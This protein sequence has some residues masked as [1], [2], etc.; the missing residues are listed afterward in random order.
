MEQRGDYQAAGAAEGRSLR[1]YELTDEQRQLRALL[2]D[3]EFEEFG[4]PVDAIHEALDVLNMAI[5]HKVEAI[6]A[7][8]TEYVVTARAIKTEI[9]R[10]VDRHRRLM[11]RADWLKGY[12]LANLTAAGLRKLE[13]ARFTV[14][15]RANPEALEVVDQGLIP[16]RFIRIEIAESVDKAAIKEALKAGAQVPGVRLTRGERLDIR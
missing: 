3:A 5:E 7:V 4:S 6:A 8:A 14:A 12:M 15:V 1:L 9:D 13:G 16:R 10:L 2:E 11:A